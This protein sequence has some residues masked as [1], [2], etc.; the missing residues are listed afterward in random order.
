MEET[1]CGRGRGGGETDEG[2]E[3]MERCGEEVKRMKKSRS[4]VISVQIGGF[5]PSHSSF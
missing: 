3:E 4:G 1:E 5:Q 2:E